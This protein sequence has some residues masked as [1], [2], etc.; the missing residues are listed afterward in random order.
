MEPTRYYPPVPKYKRLAGTIQARL[1]CIQNNNREW[2][3][4]HEETINNI[5]KSLPH[6]SGIDGVTKIDLDKSTPDKIIIY[7]EYHCM[8]ENGYYDGWVDFTITIKPSLQFGI[9]LNITGN[10]GSKNQDLKDH[11]YE[12]FDSDL[13]KPYGTEGW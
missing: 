5:I 8:N 2:E 9:D 7:S 12:T 4:N 10:F 3:E 6:G 11:L 1:N 13:R